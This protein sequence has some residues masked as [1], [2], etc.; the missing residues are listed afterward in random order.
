MFKNKLVICCFVLGFCS[1]LSLRSKLWGQATL[2][3]T[4]VSDKDMMMQLFDGLTLNNGPLG[5]DEVIWKP[6]FAERLLFEPKRDLLYTRKLADFEFTMSRY[7]KDIKQRIILFITFDGDNDSRSACHACRPV[8]SFVKLSKGLNGWGVE[9]FK[10]Y[11]G[12]FGSWGQP[13]NAKFIP[14]WEDKYLILI[15]GD[16]NLESSE[17]WLY[18]GKVV[19]DYLSFWQKGKEGEEVYHS[20]KLEVS[21]SEQCLYL[22]KKRRVEGGEWEFLG[23]EQWVFDA[24]EQSGLK[25]VCGKN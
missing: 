4:H 15:E 14:L 12:S 3:V 11:V 18:E 7:N 10:K 20:Q 6:N 2:F 25:K 13:Y 8:W 9:Q 23:R 21:R 1:V 17:T 24:K 19:Q 16:Y 5:E 22:N